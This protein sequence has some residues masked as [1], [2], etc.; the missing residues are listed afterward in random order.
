MGNEPV[1]R[2][3]PTNKQTQNKRRQTSL[4]RVVFETTIPV[5]ELAKIFHALDIAAIVTGC[6][7]AFEDNIP[8]SPAESV[9]K[10]RKAS[11][12]RS[13]VGNVQLRGMRFLCCLHSIKTNFNVEIRSAYLPN[14]DQALFQLTRVPGEGGW[15]SAD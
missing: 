7:D 5:F 3:L 12:D 8:Y 14:K 1:S 11:G 15:I 9:G 6:C 2:S 4:P 10:P 13:P